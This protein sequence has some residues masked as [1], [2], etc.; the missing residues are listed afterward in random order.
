M[1]YRNDV[2]NYINNFSHKYYRSFFRLQVKLSIKLQFSISNT[3][4]NLIFY[5]NYVIAYIKKS[6]TN[7]AYH[8]RFDIEL[9][10]IR[11]S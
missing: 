10:I 9:S 3:P 6:H 5:R 8:F 4:T 1:F 7:V 2:M 11:Q